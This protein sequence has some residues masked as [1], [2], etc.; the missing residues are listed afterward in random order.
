MRSKVVDLLKR[1]VLLTAT[2]VIMI[3]C[4]ICGS[5]L[6]GYRHKVKKIVGIMIHSFLATVL[7]FVICD[8]VKFLILAVDKAWWPSRH[9][10][11][12]VDRTAKIHTRMHY[13]KM[14]LKILRSQL[15]AT[16]KHCNE[17]L[18]LLYQS[19]TNDLWLYGRY[20]F[21]LMC[22]V[23]VTW[24][25][26][27]CYNTKH[28]E[29]LF[30]RNN[31]HGWGLEKVHS[32]ADFYK[33][34]E[35]TLVEPFDP[36]F[37][38]TGLRTW[39]YGDHT[40]KLGVVRLR[41]LRVK[42]GYHMGWKDLE[43]E[44]RDYMSRW[45]L[46]YQ[47]LPY[48]NKY[49]KI[50]TPWLPI[51]PTLSAENK[52]FLNY[53]HQGYAHDFSEL[54][55]YSTL[56]ARTAN[57]SKLVINY[58][59]DQQWLTRSKTCAIFADF[60]L[61][62]MD[63]NMFTVATLTVEV[64]AYGTFEY[65]THIESAKLL[66]LDD[67]NSIY[68]ILIVFLYILV[69]L[70]FGKSVIIMLWFEPNKLRSTWVKLDLA[71]ILLNITLICLLV[72]HQILLNSRLKRVEN[73][74]VLV[75]IDFRIPARVHIAIE[76]GLGFLVCITTL[77]LWRILQFARVFQLIT[78]TLYAA[79]KALASTAML[80][81]IFLFGFGMAV[82]IINGNYTIQFASLTNS[83]ISSVCFALGLSR[84]LNPADLLHGGAPI[85][86][87][88]YVILAFFIVI[89]MMNLFITTIRDYFGHV[90]RKMEARSVYNQI[91]FLQFLRAEYAPIF[92]YFLELPCFKRGYKSHNRTVHE[93]IEIALRSRAK[94]YRPK[95]TFYAQ[96]ADHV[97]QLK[98]IEKREEQMK[99]D[100]YKE[101]IERMHTIAA[102]MQT[103]LELL[104]HMLFTEA[105]LVRDS[106]DSPYEASESE[107]EQEDKYRR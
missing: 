76:V 91:T 14:R 89:V 81:L 102:L 68:K 33:F 2:I 13:L 44:T 54:D 59:T 80:I 52:F 21:L 99:H 95:L 17:P 96:S 51:N 12:S 22:L 94:G 65:A 62:N 57:S 6:S 46:P 34:V 78:A 49:W 26:L 36:D 7:I 39:L 45:Q 105:M 101:R 77:R 103:Q 4:L 16:D 92:R 104:N 55:G 50:Y 86:L 1:S 100:K 93:N 79:W 83:I 9:D 5:F 60:T 85:G 67:F 107:S 74:N 64:T 40:A 90:R 87:V 82:G 32:F 72:T 38:E 41:Q 24:D 58:L 15:V 19:I 11:Y 23:V 20:F 8:P 31:S 88:L 18:N 28:M 53:V 73:A 43:Y 69:F 75:F 98:D 71:I 61:F 29:A 3:I 27:L 56:L 30:V 48:T 10:S 66:M 37:E 42:E 106:E 47:Q 70:Q 63:A 84:Q 97:K 25:Q 35:S